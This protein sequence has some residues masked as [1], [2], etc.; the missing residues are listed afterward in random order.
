MAISASILRRNIYISKSIKRRKTFVEKGCFYKC[1]FSKIL[2]VDLTWKVLLYAQKLQH[3]STLNDALQFS[4]RFQIIF[5]DFL[6]QN[7]CSKRYLTMFCSFPDE[8]TSSSDDSTDT[9]PGLRSSVVQPVG[10]FQ[11]EVRSTVSRRSH[12]DDV[13]KGRNANQYPESKWDS[14]SDYVYG[15]Q[16]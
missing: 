11:S 10:G 16:M 1:Y 15:D 4:I 13:A 8:A 14:Y 5:Q 12:Y 9:F 6:I 2:V 7:K 3:Q